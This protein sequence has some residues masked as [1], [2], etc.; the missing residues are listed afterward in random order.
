MVAAVLWPWCRSIVLGVLVAVAVALGTGP[1]VVA[2]QVSTPTSIPPA[3]TYPELSVTATDKG[4]TLPAEITAGRYLVT[5]ANTGSHLIE[6]AI[7]RLPA[8]VNTGRFQNALATPSVPSW[9]GTT[10]SV[11]GPGAT[12]PGGQTQVIVDF[13]PGQYVITTL[14]NSPNFTSGLTVGANTGSAAPEAVPADLHVTLKDM[15]FDLPAKVGAG[16][17]VWQVTNTGDQLH[18]MILERVPN[19]TT[20]EQIK[21]SLTR[22]P[23]ATPPPNGLTAADFVPAGGLSELS[24]KQTAWVL[25][26]LTPGRYL[27]ISFD[28]DPHHD[29]VSQA[30]E[31]MIKLFDVTG[32]DPLPKGSKVTTTTASN[33]RAAP[34]LT[35]TSLITLPQGYALIVIGP[36]QLA[37]GMLWYP[38]QD[39]NNPKATGFVAGFLLAPAG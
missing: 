13:A 20:L 22:S 2:A 27:A 26:D 3:L 25:V 4:F 18:Q 31:G 8:D 39:A 15:S 30:R 16:Y 17:H 19:G 36:P 29:G 37:G 32:P 38:I 21:E 5:L 11:G 33:V 9:L 34:S 35:A 1:A 12:P 23:E 24:P 7:V 6:A 28:P 14:S 10:V